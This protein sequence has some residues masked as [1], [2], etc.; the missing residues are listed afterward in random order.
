MGQ[1][2]VGT[3]P[4]GIA[5]GSGSLWVANLDDQTISRVDPKTLDRLGAIT[6]GGPPTGIAAAGGRV[7]VVVSSATATSV[8]VRRIDPQFDRIDEKV[9]IGNVLP[10]SP[11]AVAARRRRALGGAVLG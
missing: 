10:G 11:G 6:V 8:S 5:F 2:A 7:W 3:R 4:G 9:P 1:V